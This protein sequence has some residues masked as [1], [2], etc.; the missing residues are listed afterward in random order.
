MYKTICVCRCI[1]YCRGAFTFPS[2]VGKSVTAQR[3]KHIIQQATSWK[4]NNVTSPRESQLSVF[5]YVL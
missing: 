3:N 2:N 5:M 4:L 1:Y